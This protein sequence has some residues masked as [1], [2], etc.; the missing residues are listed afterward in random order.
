ML[1]HPED[2]PGD[3][4]RGDDREA[5][6]DELLRL[7]AEPVRAEGEQR[8]RA[9]R[10]SSDGEADAEPDAAE[11][12]AAVDLDDVGDQDADDERGFEAFAQADQEVCEHG[13]LFMRGAQVW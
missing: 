11:H 9:P 10:E 2:H 6:A 13:L 3:E 7:E 4:R 1:Q 8:R 12:V 5:A